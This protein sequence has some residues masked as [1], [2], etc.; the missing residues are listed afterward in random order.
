MLH[1]RHPTAASGILLG[2]PSF[3]RATAWIVLLLA[4]GCQVDNSGLCGDCDAGMADSGSPSM[5]DRPIADDSDD[6]D[7]ESLDTSDGVA[8]VSDDSATIHAPTPP[9][10]GTWRRD[11]SRHPAIFSQTGAPRLWGLSDVHGDRDR[12]IALLAA[13]GL[14]DGNQTLPTWTGGRDTLVVSGDNIDKG[15][16]SVEVLDTWTTLMPQ[17]EL[18]G[19]HLVVLLGNHEAEFLADPS[20]DKAGPLVA[21]LGGGSAVAFASPENSHGRFMRE[22]P[23][24]AVVDGWFFSHAGNSGGRTVEQLAATFQ[25]LVDADDWSDAFFLDPNSILEARNWWPETETTSFLDGYLSA[26][27]AHHIVFGHRP[28]TFAD[29]PTGNIEVHEQGRLVLI[30]V[31][32]SRAVDYSTGKLLRVDSP[33]TPEEA[34]QMVT[35]AGDVVR[36]DLTAP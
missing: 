26:L 30:D 15:M 9:D 34:V 1:P 29:P 36:L 10:D 7:A 2:A 13:A 35:P 16:Q 12:L 22:S 27:P 19:G 17:A 14:I 4:T 24:A 6:S 33:G 31:G 21:E 28:V 20:N 5:A 3:S 23:I 32:M 25:S 18:A 11:W 8:S